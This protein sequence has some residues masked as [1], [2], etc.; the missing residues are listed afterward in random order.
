MSQALHAAHGQLHMPHDTAQS[1]QALHAQL[2]SHWQFTIPKRALSSLFLSGVKTG[3]FIESSAFS[4][5]SGVRPAF[6]SEE[7][8]MEAQNGSFSMLLLSGAS[9]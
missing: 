3:S 6:P 8:N 1:P 9:R 2:H 5:I 7:L 4:I